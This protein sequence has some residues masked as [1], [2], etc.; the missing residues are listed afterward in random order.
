[1]IPLRERE[2]KAEREQ[3]EVVDV[4]EAERLEAVEEEL[5]QFEEG[6]NQGAEGEVLED[7]L[8]AELQAQEDL[9]A[10]I[11]VILLIIS[12]RHAMLSFE[13]V[14]R[15]SLWDLVSSF[16]KTVSKTGHKAQASYLY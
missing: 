16:S 14:K 11:Q 5:Q 6:A 2:V 12:A 13:N 1:M 10:L 3:V 4:L 7:A 15:L 8:V 9:P